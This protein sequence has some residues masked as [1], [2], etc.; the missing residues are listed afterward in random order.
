MTGGF[1]FR[2]AKEVDRPKD[3]FTRR[4]ADVVKKFLKRVTK[5]CVVTVWET[6]D[7]ERQTGVVQGTMI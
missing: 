4:L 7:L 1:D 6:C 2:R 3:W 5:S